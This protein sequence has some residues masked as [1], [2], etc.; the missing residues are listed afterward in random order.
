LKLLPENLID[1]GG[2]LICVAAAIST[3]THENLE[4]FQFDAF[5]NDY[6]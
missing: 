3:N 6:P 1:A 5:A 2:L 4:I